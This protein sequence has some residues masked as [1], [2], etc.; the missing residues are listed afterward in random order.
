[1]RLHNMQIHSDLSRCASR[2]MTMER[3][4]IEA[5]KAGIETIGISD[6][7]DYL[8]PVREEQILEN[9]V[10]RDKLRPAIDVKIGCEASQINPTTI[11]IRSNTAEE[12]DFVLVAANHYHL[13]QVENPTGKS[14]LAYAQ[15][16]LKMIQGAIN[17]SHTTI[18]PHPFY[19][20]KVRQI[21]HLLVMDS[22]DQPQLNRVLSNAAKNSVAFE[23]NPRQVIKSPE[24]FQL[25]VRRGQQLGVKFALG[26]DAHKPEDIQYNPSDLQI[27]EHIGVSQN[28]LL[29]V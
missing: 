10:L 16:H 20:S 25:L 18:I 3:I 4:I 9:F 8:D 26:T 19:L 29:E 15:H 11:A 1:M 2:Q 22:Y 23:I 14:P 7:I 6:H 24:F 12:L 27:L 17:W 28:H 21:D 5:E 13:E